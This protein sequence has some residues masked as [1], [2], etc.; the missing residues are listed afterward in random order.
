MRDCDTHLRQHNDN[1]TF[2]PQ[3]D[4]ELCIIVVRSPW[5]V[6][7]RPLLRDMPIWSEESGAV[8]ARVVA[9]KVLVRDPE[10]SIVAEF[11]VQKLHPLRGP[12]L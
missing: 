1:R 6:H 9:Q 5:N 3:S 10:H 7:R 12:L 4:T 8:K 11:V 2:F